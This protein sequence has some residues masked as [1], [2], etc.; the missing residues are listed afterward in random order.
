[1]FTLISKNYFIINENIGMQKKE[2]FM[3]NLVE[4]AKKGKRVALLEL[5]DKYWKE[6][7]IVAS[8]LL[9]EDNAA[10]IAVMQAFQHIWDSL[11]GEEGG[12]EGFR[13][14]L[15]S[16]T[17]FF[18]RQKNGKKKKISLT[19]PPNKNFLV[20]GNDMEAAYQESDALASVLQTLPA[21]TRF[22]FVLNQI[23]GFSKTEIAAATGL[24]EK[25]VELAL[26][27][28]PQNI[29]GILTAFSQKSGDFSRKPSEILEE[30]VLHG[31]E[32]A[33]LPKKQEEKIKESIE[34]FVE[35]FEKKKKKKSVT[36]ASAVIAAA[37]VLCVIGWF[38][39]RGGK[40]TQKET[41]S[42]EALQEGA[43]STEALQE[44]AS[45]TEALQ[46]GTEALEASNYAKIEIQDYGSITV[47]LNKEA[48]P[49]TVENFISLAES[50]F[51]NGLTFHRIIEGFMMQGGD[52][53][54]D[55]SGG[56][57]Q[58]ITGEFTENGFE[59][60]LSHTR[61]A[62]SMARSLDNDSASSQFFIVHQDSLFLDGKYAVFGYVT[63]GMDIVDAVCSAAEPTDDDG[64]IPPEQQ[65][66]ITSIQIFD[67]EE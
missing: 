42:T 39:F 47:A 62:I 22:V 49:K 41:S 43:S 46:E 61:G 50:G 5:Y 25:T 34:A 7:K 3:S 16:E 36:A 4:Q 26:E 65:P 59:N 31:K 32:D 23:A 40:D 67:A 56:S 27:A 63:E 29:N 55:G 53:N 57:E 11:Q 44:G 66:V 8:S 54:G 9:M 48:A 1:M 13:K 58:T 17:V 64:T 12:E 18:C 60:N 19:V 30:A 15:I 45:S 2:E 28:Q 21:S 14:K 38:A 51:Y 20:T 37:A 35:P 52:P 24:S 6:A 33:V 10:N